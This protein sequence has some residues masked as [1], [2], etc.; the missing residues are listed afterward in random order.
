MPKRETTTEEVT[1]MR[2]RVFNFH[3]GNIENR[4][5][6][7]VEFSKELTVS[8]KALTDRQLT[9]RNKVFKDF[10]KNHPDHIV[11]KKEKVEF[12]KAGGKDLTRDRRQ[13][14]NVVGTRREY[15]KIGA[16]RSDLRGVD[17]KPAKDKFTKIGKSKGRIVYGRPVIVTIKGKKIK[18]FRDRK[19]HFIS[20]KKKK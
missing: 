20:V 1:R 4:K 7:D 5:T 12:K 19:G 15:R 6:F 18:R 13:T 2:E 3:K 14:R 10:R 17:T 8:E 9:F 16:S 11:E